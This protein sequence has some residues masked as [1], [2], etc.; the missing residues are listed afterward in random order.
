MRADPK[1]SERYLLNP[2][3]GWIVYQTDL[4]KPD[5]RFLGDDIGSTSLRG[6]FLTVGLAW[7]S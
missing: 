6:A 1:E 4:I 7:N 3:N 2:G 5:E